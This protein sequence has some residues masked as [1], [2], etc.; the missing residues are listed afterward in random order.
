MLMFSTKM[1]VTV[2][3]LFVFFEAVIVLY[4][5]PYCTYCHRISHVYLT[6]ARYFRAVRHLIFTRID[7]ENND[8]PWEFTMHHY[9]T[10]LFFP[11]DRYV[12]LQVECEKLQKLLWKSIAVITNISKLLCKYVTFVWYM[13]NIKN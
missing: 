8:L 11:P 7:G 4:H 5:S 3:N 2:Y 1:F 13:F 6:V 10:I 9:P 12:T